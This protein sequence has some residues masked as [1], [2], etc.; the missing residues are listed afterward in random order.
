M[1]TATNGREQ[2]AIT[3]A[4]NGSEELELEKGLHFRTGRISHG[5]VTP[6]SANCFT[7]SDYTFSL[8]R[9]L[10]LALGIGYRGP[11]SQEQK[12]Q[13]GLGFQ[14]SYPFREDTRRTVVIVHSFRWDS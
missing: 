11:L 10:R 6:I 9:Q 3:I 1:T 2:V 12:L 14:Q 5:E 4:L 13:I 7:I 8:I